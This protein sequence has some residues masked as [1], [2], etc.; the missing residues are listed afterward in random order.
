MVQYTRFA[1]PALFTAIA[2]FCGYLWLRE[3]VTTR[4]YRQKLDA[5][6]SEYASLAD[7]YNHAVR[8]S[9]IT[10]LEVQEDSLTVIIRTVDGD[11]KRIPTPYHP[12]REIFVDYILSD[13]R[14]WIR[15]VFD[16]RTPPEQATIIDPVWE[17]ID[18]KKMGLNYGKA[19]YR[20]LE[21]GIWSIQ[22]SG[23][24]ALSLERSPVSSVADLQAAPVIRSYEEIRIDLDQ[25]LKEIGYKDFRDVLLSPLK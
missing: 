4:I 1:F 24:G 13:G 9:A 12:A 5:L 7:H 20:S 21:P 25:D 10:E 3:E 22:V 23:N 2:V 17:V 6:A 11:I 15:R 18:W 19:I 14:I 16:G 8:Q